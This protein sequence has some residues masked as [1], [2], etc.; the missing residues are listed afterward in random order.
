[1]FCKNLLQ[2]LAIFV[3]SFIVIFVDIIVPLNHPIF[4]KILRGIF[5]KNNKYM[6]VSISKKSRD[7]EYH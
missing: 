7:L 2:F 5:Y 4:S 1:M 3:F 6:Y